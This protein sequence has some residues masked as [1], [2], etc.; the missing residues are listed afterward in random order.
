MH[1]PQVMQD[2]SGPLRISQPVGHTAAHRLQ[3][4]QSPMVPG[5]FSAFFTLPRGSPRQSL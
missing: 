3:S 2:M 1:R 5:F 4:T